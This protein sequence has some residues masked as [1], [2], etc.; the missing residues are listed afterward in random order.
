M[1]LKNKKSRLA[2]AQRA[3]GTQ[4]FE[5]GFTDSIEEYIADP[6][7]LPPEDL[8]DCGSEDDGQGWAFSMVDGEIKCASEDESDSEWEDEEDTNLQEVVGSKR[9]AVGEP[10]SEEEDLEELASFEAAETAQKLWKE[11]LDKVRS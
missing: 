1:P 8:E 4:F 5:S 3:S 11:F 9:K 7:Y 2:K 10:E 6:T